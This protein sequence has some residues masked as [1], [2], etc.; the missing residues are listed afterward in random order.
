MCCRPE[1]WEGEVG[2]DLLAY[3]QASLHLPFLQALFLVLPRISGVSRKHVWDL[4]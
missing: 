4:E 1:G 2:S 3:G